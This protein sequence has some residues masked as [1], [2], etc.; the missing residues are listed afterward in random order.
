M[1]IKQ[2]YTDMQTALNNVELMIVQMEAKASGSD[3]YNRVDYSGALSSL[4]NL[5]RN[6]KRML[7]IHKIQGFSKEEFINSN[8]IQNSGSIVINHTVKKW[9][10][11]TSIAKLYN[12]TIDEILKIN[13]I[14]SDDLVPGLALI[15]KTS[16]NIMIDGKQN[17]SVNVPVYGSRVGQE[18]YGRDWP[19]EFMANT[20]ADDLKVLDPHETLKQGITNRLSTKSGDYP[21]EDDFG[22]SLVGSE[23]PKELRDGLL[24]IE[25]SQQLEQD[26]RIESIEN[27]IVTSEANS[28]S[29]EAVVNA[30]QGAETILATL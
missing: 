10:S 13:N 14:A 23:Y 6:I 28:T 18:V 12:T 29:F 22:I 16:N 30:V 24:T 8:A 9:E 4:Y 27:I 26:T 20:S 15:I 1:D 21:M 17:N 7:I 19:N 2:Y 25:A 5:K 3:E 11:V